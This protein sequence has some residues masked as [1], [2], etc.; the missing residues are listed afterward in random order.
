M[1]SST[2]HTQEVI[3]FRRAIR[4]AA[5]ALYHIRHVRV[6]WKKAAAAA[7]KK[8]KSSRIKEQEWKKKRIERRPQRENSLRIIERIC[9][10]RHFGWLSIFSQC[11]CDNSIGATHSFFLCRAPCLEIF[12]S[13]SIRLIFIWRLGLVKKPISYGADKHIAF[14]ISCSALFL[15]VRCSFFT[16]IVFTCVERI[17]SIYIQFDSLLKLSEWV[18]RC[19]ICSTLASEN[20]MQDFNCLKRLN[21]IFFTIVL[22][23]GLHI[24]SPITISYQSKRI[25]TF[26]F[27]ATQSSKMTQEIYDSCVI[28]MNHICHSHSGANAL[29]HSQQ[30][31]NGN[32][33]SE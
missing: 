1:K 32:G 31:K 26:V 5:Y 29:S 8:N 6:G 13:I 21:T 9:L 23:I 12:V 3:G 16:H 20:N 11:V 18:S 27:S 24:T 7:A 30:I 4:S 17:C 2:V 22:H 19:M 15:S 33:T 28:K 10:R 25:G 14:S